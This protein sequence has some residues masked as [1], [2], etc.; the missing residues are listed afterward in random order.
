MPAPCPETGNPSSCKIS[1]SRLHSPHSD[2][3]SAPCLCFRRARASGR[4]PCEL[5]SLPSSA[6]ASR[7]KPR[8][9]NLSCASSTTPPARTIALPRSPVFGWERRVFGQKG[10][11]A[12]RRKAA[13]CDGST[14]KM[15]GDGHV[16][17]IGH[18]GDHPAGGDFSYPRSEDFS[19][20]PARGFEG[21]RTRGSDTCPP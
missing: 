1:T 19:R 9:G 10:L 20:L 14:E 12:R 2:S 17:V 5:P 18:L 6:P 21:A 13:R 8:A 4:R 11:A 7:A 3:S 15:S 16:A